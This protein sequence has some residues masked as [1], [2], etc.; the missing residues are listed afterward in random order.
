MP[1]A[2]AISAGG[3]CCNIAEPAALVAA[4]GGNGDN[5]APDNIAD[6]SSFVQHGADGVRR[7]HLYVDN[8]RCAG[9]IRSIEAALAAIPGID[10]SR[11]NM[12]TGRLAV[13]WTD[14]G[15]SPQRIME[16]L[17]KLGYPSAPFDPELLRDRN[18]AQDRDLLSSL[19]VAGFA[20]AN[21]MLLSVSV[22]AGA[23]SDMGPATRD[24]FHWLSA[25]IALPAV[26]YAGRPFFRSAAGALRAGRTNMDVPISLAVL[27]AAGMSLHQTVLG[28]EH[29]YFDAS[30][31]LLFFL[32][33]GRYLDQRARTKAR[34]AT[35]HLVGLTTLTATVID[36]KGERHL[37]PARDV[38]PNA[39]VIVASGERVPV[40]GV[41]IDGRSTVDNSLVTGET[42]PESIGADSKV[43]AGTINVSA[44]IV[45]RAAA[46]GEGTLLAEIVRL[47]EAAEHG[48][49]KYVAIADRAARLY[50]P[51]VHAI[52]ALTFLGW[53]SVAGST[54]EHAVMMAVAVLII[55]CPCALG[56]AVPAVQVAA[57]GVLLR[58]GVLIKSRDALE[59]AGEVDTVIF[60]KTGT[61][62]VGR[63]ELV[64]PEDVD[65]DMLRLAAS[66]AQ[67]SKHPLSRAVVRACDGTPWTATDVV[68][69]PGLGLAGRVDGGAV[70]LG[71]AAWCGAPET[72]GAADR[73]NVLWLRVGEAAPVPFQF[74]DRMREDTAAVVGRLRD[75]GLDVRLV[76]GDREAAVRFA[77]DSL[78]ISDW[79]G[80]CRPAEKTRIIEALA[81]EG[82]RVLMVGDGLND[83]PA[84]A[85]GHASISPASGSDISQ[86]A[87][88][89]VF[90][91]ARL[92]S[93]VTILR[94]ARAANRLVKQNMALAILYNLIAV[95]IAVLGYVTPL[96]AAA[97][98]SS[99]SL[100]VTLN[101][102]RLHWVPR[103]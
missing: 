61:L 54:V 15:V 101:A 37:V 8:L 20:A 99:S 45:I 93:V 9:C 102:L 7:L 60:D 11:V 40:D 19:A 67:H 31:M 36:E 89:F 3:D 66:L 55:T 39:R 62:T 27:L 34:S 78:A 58:A 29:A 83:A 71:S 59:R 96:I 74:T 38:V 47:V 42:L 50:A 24:F 21:V 46:T 51:A 69:E 41:V 82:R 68:E 5:L 84:L 13:R 10:D 90:Q 100:V 16:T 73:N 92:Q 14:P 4:Q 18:A 56:L 76:S 85:A 64:D 23:F 22:W 88:D 86:A 25:A 75:L 1:R 95:P 98:M 35:A 63:P 44:P 43:F 65:P 26:A 97:A 87:A 80:G 53:L 72:G 52:A 70:R 2:D 77:A 30:I 32:L 81:A 103:R 6:P 12:S 49:T 57:A 91:G 48:R 17:A 94:V 33:I 28:R 79:Q